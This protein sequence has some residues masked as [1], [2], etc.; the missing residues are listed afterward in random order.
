MLNRIWE[1]LGI[2]IIDRYILKKYLQTFFYSLLL[3]SLIAIFI[4]VSEK[5][6]DFIRRKPPL[7]VLIFDYYIY[8]IPWFMGLF[9]SVFAF[10]ATLLFNAKL[11]QNSEIIAILNSGVKYPKFLKPYLLGATFLFLIFLLLNTHIIPRAEKY[12]L[13]F[14]DDWIH[15]RK[16]TENNNLYSMLNDS[17]VIHMESF[18]YTDS[19]GFNVVLECF[20]Q[21]RLISRVY[22]GR[23]IWDKQKQIWSLE[24][25]RNRIFNADGSEIILKRERLD[26]VLLIKPDEFIVKSKYISSMTNPELNEFIRKEVEKGSAG[27]G[28]YYVELYKRTSIPFAFYVLTIMAVAVSS[29]KSR[30]GMGFS[31]GLGVIITFVYLLFIQVFSTMGNSGVIPA[32]VAVWAPTFIFMLIALLLL[33][34]APK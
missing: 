34:L 31:L 11:A 23:L 2:G 30:G 14:E 15:D 12:K 19:I 13:K 3:F 32:W 29:S 9:S 33:R 22:A 21:S 17:S 16:P 25:Y 24:G 4:D 8:F 28:K 20:S 26:T 10:L 1:I 7:F 5:M 18:N 27:T 6:N